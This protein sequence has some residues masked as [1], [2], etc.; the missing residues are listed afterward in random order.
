MIFAEKEDQA[1][2]D[3]N[4]YT[5]RR[6]VLEFKCLCC[7]HEEIISLRV[8]SELLQVSLQSLNLFCCR[9]V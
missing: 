7:G 6:Y 4:I 2:Y 5:V 1:K 3:N 8:Q 9:W